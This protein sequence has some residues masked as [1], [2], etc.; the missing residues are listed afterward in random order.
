MENTK[1]S[2]TSNI[3]KTVAQVIIAI[4][5][6]SLIGSQIKKEVVKLDFK[7]ISWLMHDL[8]NSTFWLIIALGVLG[9]AILSLYDFFVLRAIAIHKNMQSIRIFKISFMTNSLNM[10]LGF[11][12]FIGAGLRYY[13]Y[14]PYSKNNNNNLLIAIGMILI[15]ML[16]GISLLSIL[17]V[18]DILPGVD[19]YGDKQYLY[20][21]LLIISAFL[22]IY[23]FINMRNPK[24][25]TDKYLAIKL[26]IISFFEWIYAALLVIFILYIFVGDFI[27]GK[28]LRIVGIIV[29][30]AIAG[31]LSMIPSGVGIFDY[32]VFA[33]L[34]NLGF[35]GEVIAVTLFLYRLSYYI[36]PFFIGI[37]L[38]ASEI[39]VTIGKKIIKKEIVDDN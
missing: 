29:V 30:A 3:F 20:Y 11:G 37:F 34:L 28:E 36:V 13:F 19:L 25:K 39:L 7:K 31:L 24:I 33:G 26:A 15:S 22:P 2:K 35:S 38:L 21:F 23:L 6:L 9:M 32:L 14:K 10:L 1:K 4:V 8:G 18:I 27:F 16:S 17:V 12:G 5:I